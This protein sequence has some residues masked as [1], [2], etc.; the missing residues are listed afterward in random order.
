MHLWFKPFTDV[1]FAIRPSIS[2]TT[3]DLVFHKVSFVRPT[4]SNIQH[5]LAFFESFDKI[6]LIVRVIRPFFYSLTMLQMFKPIPFVTCPICLWTKA[7]S[8]EFVGH[9]L[10]WK[11]CFIF[12][13]QPSVSRW[14]AIQPL[15]EIVRFIWE[16]A[17][18]ES[19][20][21]HV[22]PSTDINSAIL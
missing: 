9:P 19:M 15:A 4:I 10:S 1:H 12:V 16:Y 3:T 11:H 5:A 7:F 14:L 18:S 20:S 2:A 21:K 8:M 22:Q 13:D 6:A 17:E